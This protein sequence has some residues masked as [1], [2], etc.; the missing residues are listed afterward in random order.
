MPTQAQDV[1]E[2]LISD[3]M[4]VLIEGLPAENREKIQK[5]IAEK[6]ISK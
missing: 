2:Q 4:Q 5:M 1:F 3:D 6:N